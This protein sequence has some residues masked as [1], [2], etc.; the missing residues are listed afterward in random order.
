MVD[1]R[2]EEEYGTES[3]E[4]RALPYE[5]REQAELDDLRE[6]GQKNWILFKQPKN[7]AGYNRLKKETK[8][9]PRKGAYL[10]EG[11]HPLVVKIGNAGTT[12][13]RLMQLTKKGCEL[14]CYDMTPELK[15]T[16][17]EDQRISDL[18]TYLEGHGKTVL[19]VVE[20]KASAKKI[21]DDFEKAKK[22]KEEEK[23]IKKAKNDK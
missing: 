14:V 23:E 3:M 15:A 13:Q 20:A 21:Q 12:M 4:R 18:V 10:L 19:E 8:K 11:F 5:K 7:Q 1:R 2:K 6:L 22:A 9:K 16:A 17:R